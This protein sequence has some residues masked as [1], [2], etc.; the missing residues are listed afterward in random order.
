MTRRDLEDRIHIGYAAVQMNGND[1]L[2]RTSD[3]TLDEF[4]IE[5]RGGWV[6]IH[7]NGTRATV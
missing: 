4:R 7:E 1:G 5:I 6:N 3:R 2:R